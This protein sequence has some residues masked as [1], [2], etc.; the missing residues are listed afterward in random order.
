[1]KTV[2]FLEVA[3]MQYVTTDITSMTEFCIF[4][5]CLGNAYTVMDAQANREIPL[6]RINGRFENLPKFKL[7]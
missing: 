3:Y 5:N 2:Y 6:T 1:M 4:M 7:Q